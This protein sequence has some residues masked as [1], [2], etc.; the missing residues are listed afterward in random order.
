[1]KAL[2]FVD[3]T[4]ALNEIDV[5]S[6]RDESLIRV[7]MSGICNTDLEIVRGYAGFSGT[8]GHEFVGVVENDDAEPS[9]IG[10]RVVGEINAGCGECDKCA[11]GD[12]R[13]CDTRT[14]LGIVNRDGAHS[15]FVSLP[16]RNLVFIPDDLADE[17][18]V[19]AEP[20][21][22]ALGISERIS[23]QAS[24]KIAVIGDGKLGLFCSYAMK[25]FS[26]DVTLIGK[27]TG[28]LALAEKRNIKALLADE[29][30]AQMFRQFDI[31][32]EASGS[33]SGFATAVD[34][35]RPRGT[36]VLK[37]TFQ[38]TPTWPASRIVVDEIAVVG[39]RCGR[40]QSAIDLLANG[41]IDPTD[42][43][44]TVMPL[45]DG[46]AAMEL[47]ATKGTLKVLLKIP[48]RGS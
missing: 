41:I 42:M 16:R 2:Q 29:I 25:Q 15:E 1:M 5:P 18:A 14:V 12:S 8:I 20:L 40:L 48:T 35:V 10:R 30:D 38:G 23:I 43:I 44:D 34:L 32:V 13:H 9:L 31:V 27:H 6:R 17:K 21:A 22:A 19:F 37:S 11:A 36:I 3:G 39:S 28:K 26:D 7:T 4:L 24:D 47:A 46:V 33:E 45:S